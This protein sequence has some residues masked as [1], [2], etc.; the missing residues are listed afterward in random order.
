MSAKSP[1]SAVEP[2]VMPCGLR[3]AQILVPGA[4]RVG[5]RLLS[6]G[7]VDEKP[8]SERSFVPDATQMTRPPQFAFRLLVLLEVAHVVAVVAGSEDH[9]DAEVRQ[10]LRGDADG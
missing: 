6:V 5:V 4:V 8:D 7:P 9:G 10:R 2:V 1:E 3:V